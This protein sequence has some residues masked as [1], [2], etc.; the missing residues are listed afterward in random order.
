MNQRALLPC[1]PVV[2]ISEPTDVEQATECMTRVVSPMR[3]HGL[4][5][6]TPAAKYMELMAYRRTVV[7]GHAARVI[8]SAG[9]APCLSMLRC[10]PEEIC[11]GTN[12]AQGPLY[13]R[14]ES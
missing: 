4:L 11:A 1:G 3:K 6:E 8:A 9:I 2:M 14:G 13:T 10:D 5:G 12:D 7:T